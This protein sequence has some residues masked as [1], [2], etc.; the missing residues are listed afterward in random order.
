M[1]LGNVVNYVKFSVFYVIRSDFKLDCKI[2]CSLPNEKE[3]KY[4]P[5]L[6]T[7]KKRPLPEFAEQA[8]RVFQKELRT[9]IDLP[10]A[11]IDI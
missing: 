5:A 11:F 6:D 2:L 3:S 9:Y 10:I 8:E 1:K 7:I 4:S